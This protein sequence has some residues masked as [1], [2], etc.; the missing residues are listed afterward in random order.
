MGSNSSKREPVKETVF[1]SKKNKVYRIPALFYHREE[2]VFMAFAEQRSSPDDS[3][4][5]KLVMKTGTLKEGGDTKMVEWSYLRLLDEAQLEGYRPMN[6]CPLYERITKTLF[7]FFICV[8]GN[9]SEGWQITTGCNQTRLCYITTQDVG[10]SWSEVTDL[11]DQLDMSNWATFAVGPGHGIQTES[12]RLIVPLYAYVSS[13]KCSCCCC[14]WWWCRCRCRLF[15]PHALY[16]YSNDQGSNW[17]LGD[18]LETE[19]VECQ[20]A[21]VSDETGQKSIYCNARTKGGHRVEAFD[22]GSGFTSLQSKLTETG[23]G[24][25][26]SVVSFPAQREDP[27]VDVNPI[28]WL[29]FTHPSDAS[30]RDDLGVYLNKSPSNTKAWSGPWVIN[31]GP[32]GYSDLTYIDDGWF[33]C[34]MERGETKI[35]EEIVFVVFSCKGMQGGIGAQAACS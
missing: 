16:L 11:T 15:S 9:V 19:S 31:E 28:N 2:K 8:R 30:E 6:P 7:L 3:S 4:T 21:E 27:Q 26:G 33:G 12:G 23:N 13:S 24:C 22:K 14:S 35:H 34:L 25:Q 20:M 1:L 29:L 17:Q 5:K 18:M 32:S 10:R